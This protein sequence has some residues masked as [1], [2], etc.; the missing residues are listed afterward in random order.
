MHLYDACTAVPNVLCKA[1]IRRRSR[2]VCHISCHAPFLIQR[3]TGDGNAGNTYFVAYICLCLR[4]QIA[5][6]GDIYS[7]YGGWSSACLQVSARNNTQDLKQI[8]YVRTR[9]ACVLTAWRAL[10]TLFLEQEGASH[11]AAEALGNRFCHKSH[12]WCWYRI[13][14][15]CRPLLTKGWSYELVSYVGAS[16]GGRSGDRGNS[17]IRL[18]ADIQ[19]GDILQAP[20]PLESYVI[21]IVYGLV[22][23]VSGQPRRILPHSVCAYCGNIFYPYRKEEE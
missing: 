12:F 15:E 13:Q 20:I 8:A 23:D 5:G 1:E 7:L 16:G 19:N 18:S 6:E 3:R 22:A 4:G 2:C 11:R 17:G 9:R 21:C 10:P 14:R